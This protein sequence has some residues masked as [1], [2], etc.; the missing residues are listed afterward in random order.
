M[1]TPRVPALLLI[2][3]SLVL[4]GDF[5]KAETAGVRNSARRSAVLAVPALLLL[6]LGRC[7][8]QPNDGADRV[9]RKESGNPF[10]QTLSGSSPNGLAIGWVVHVT[11]TPGDAGAVL[12]T[13][14]EVARGETYNLIYP[15]FNTYDELDECLDLAEQLGLRVIVSIP[16]HDLW[17]SR[18][19]A[20]NENRAQLIEFL[21][22]YRGRKCIYAWN[23]A[24]EPEN[25]IIPLSAVYDPT[26]TPAHLREYDRIIKTLDPGTPTTVICIG[27][28][29]VRGLPSSTS[30]LEVGDFL[31]VDCYPITLTTPVDRPAD[32]MYWVPLSLRIALQHAKGLPPL[33]IVQGHGTGPRTS[34]LRLPTTFET[35]YMT[36]SPLT[37]D[38]QGILYYGK[39][40]T[41]LAH[42]REV[43]AV[44]SVLR[45]L[46]PSESPLADA[47]GVTVTASTD[48]LPK[49][50]E[51]GGSLDAL[52]YRL[53]AM[54]GMGADVPGFVLIASNNSSRVASPTFTVQ[55]FPSSSF[56]VTA[57][58]E[59]DGPDRRLPAVQEASS[60]SFSD[61]FLEK[62][63]HVYALKVVSVGL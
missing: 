4:D 9:A 62:Q 26:C 47:V 30:Y 5:W 49:L 51:L 59:L 21:E 1:R 23:L 17:D 39:S 27:A 31:T 41:D 19:D 56:E 54:Q 20:A 24:D 61:S 25:R 45:S 52:T 10:A 34:P 32:R 60:L 37:L 53:F 55:G 44:A 57:V 33:L 50:R 36:L 40:E 14:Q 13:L 46:F 11:R 42:F 15:Y 28:S 29:L 7:A 18:Q 8:S 35:R 12:Q 16:R 2:L 22:K 58:Y 48:S 6:V 38:C 3:I 43:T 63:V